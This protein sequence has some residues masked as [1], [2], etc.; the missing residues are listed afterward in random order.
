MSGTVGFLIG[1]ILGTFL[2]SRLFL[3]IAKKIISN[4]LIATIIAYVFFIPLALITAA[5][6]AAN[7]GPLVWGAGLIYVP[8][9]LI[10]LV[11][12]IFRLKRG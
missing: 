7:G 6:G 11:Y 8:I 4:K 1:A 9:A 12:D 2:F 10:F 5:T 3:W